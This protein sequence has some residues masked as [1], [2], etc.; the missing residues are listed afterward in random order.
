MKVIGIIPARYSSTRFPGK[1]L[2]D[3]KGKVMIQRVYEEASKCNSLDEVIVATDDQRIFDAVKAFG[4]E[5]EMTSEEHRSGTDRCGE[6]AAKYNAD[7][8][9]NIQGDEPLVNPGQ[10]DML[11]TTFKDETVN[12]ATLGYTQVSMEDLDD[13]NR[14]KVVCDRHGNALYF[15]RSPIPSTQRASEKMVTQ[16][17]FMRHIGLYAY[18]KETLTKLVQLTPCPL[19]QMEDLEQLRWMYYGF[20]IRVIPTSIETPNIDTPEDLERVI[21]EL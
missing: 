7:V 6:V 11:C 8:I 10:I 9:V 19:E 13:I 5:V 16:F 12:I 2:V 1:P 18:R 21:N 15:S 4:G 20:K 17:P 3:L 14:V